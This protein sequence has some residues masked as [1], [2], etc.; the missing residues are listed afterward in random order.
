MWSFSILHLYLILLEG[1]SWGLD[2]TFTFGYKI[3]LN[4]LLHVGDQLQYKIGQEIAMTM[5]GI[6]ML[7]L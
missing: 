4:E 6:T 2:F 7:Q 5:T 3:F 1:L